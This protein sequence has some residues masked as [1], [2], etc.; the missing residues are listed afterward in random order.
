MLMRH[1]IDGWLA[2]PSADPR[3]FVADAYDRVARLVRA[4]GPPP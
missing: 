2:S 3:P 1:A 4:A